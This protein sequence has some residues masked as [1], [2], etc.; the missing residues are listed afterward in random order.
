MNYRKYCPLPL[1]VLLFLGLLIGACSRKLVNPPAEGFNAA[2]SDAKAMALADQVMTAMGGRM[3]WDATR[4]ISWNFF[5]A[6]TLL[7]DK[8]T[9]QCRIEWK[10][11]DLKVIINVNT[12]KGKVAM[13]GIEQTNPDTLAKYLDA[14][15]RAWI[16]DSYWLLMPFKLKDSGVTLKY[17]GAAQTEKGA[18]AELLQMTFA[19][20]GVTPENKY[21]V[22]VDQTTHLVTQWAYFP[23]FTDEKPMFV[24]PWNDY[25]RYGSILISGDRGRGEVN[26]LPIAVLPEAPAG[27]F[28]TW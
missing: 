6:R 16:N 18:T 4:C 28:D 19:G 10:K 21:H 27:A 11:R 3:A 17:L 13:D 2:A 22:W 9:G 26:L 12:G 5:G 15:K 1:A 20:V 8:Y 7:W 23:K 24:N 14:G 25:K